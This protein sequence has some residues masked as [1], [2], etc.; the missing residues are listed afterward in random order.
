MQ[1]GAQAEDYLV[2]GFYLLFMVGIG[3]YFSRFMKG[4][5]DFF[6]GGN[7]I[8]WWVSGVSLYMT[9]FSAWTFTGAASFTYHTGWF[10]LLYFGTWPVAFFFGFQMSARRWR[11]TRITSPVEYLHVRF[12]RPTHLFLSVMMAL[13]MLYWPAHHLAS[14]AKI[15][16]P[17][18]FPNSMVAVDAMIIVTGIVILIYTYAGGLWAVCVTDV[19]QF[20]I[21]FVVCLVLLPV[22][23]LSGDIA[24]PAEFV[25]RIPAL[26]LRHVLP[27]KT[28]YD[29]WYLL[30]LIA[31][32]IFGYSVGEKAQRYYSVRDEAAAMRVGWLTFGLFLTGPLLFG[33][34]P[35][36]GKYLWPQVEML[37]QI[38]GVTKPDET[39][40]IAVVMHYLPAG[41]V[42][43]FL[44][45][46]MA[47]SMSSMSGI[48]NTVSSIVSV[49]IYKNLFK[50]HATEKETLRVGRITVFVF[51]MIAMAIAL[52]IIHSRYGIFSVTNIFFGLTSVPI[53]I[54]LVLGILNR[55]ISR[56]SAMA[57]IL[58]GTFVASGARFILHFTL[59]FQFLVTVGFTLLFIFILTP[60]GKLYRHHRL[61]TLMTCILLGIFIWSGSIIFSMNPQLSFTS[62]RSIGVGIGVNLLASAHFWNLVLALACSMLAYGFASLAAREMTTPHSAPT[63]FFAKMDKPIDVEKEVIAAGAKETNIFPLVGG[64]TMIF[65]AISLLMLIFPDARKKVAVNLAISGILFVIGLLMMLSKKMNRQ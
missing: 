3:F 29:Q 55:R 62:L 12:N 50:P 36:I 14:L 37:Q 41:V 52:I 38:F 35:L 24:S 22:I 42:G 21:L 56:W 47:A 45:A 31:A 40:F 6:V 57:S 32:N 5:K 8:P 28:V 10:G 11:R 65:S 9:M 59:G 1:L 20:L 43:I 18:L 39:I 53:A 61:A 51:A 4:G 27:D 17:A 26:Q 16:A 58:A 25:A 64:I 2:I 19:V 63:E 54:P 48:W 60:L 33:L 46:M 30:G 34:P 49:D 23:F 44:S 13:G 15:C 7:M